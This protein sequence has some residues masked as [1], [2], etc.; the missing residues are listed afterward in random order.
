VV[1][2]AALLSNRMQG[3]V[4]YLRVPEFNRGSAK[5]IRSKLQQFERQ[6]LHKLVLDLRGCAAGEPSEAIETAQLFL[7]SGTIATLRGQTIPEQTFPADSSK[8][9]WQDP[10]TVLTSNSTAGPAEIL[11]A[12]IAGNSR[13]DTIGR[14]TLGTASEQKL[15]P[16]ED[17]SAIFLTV[18]IYYTPDNKAI[19]NA[20]VTPTVRVPS[21]NSQLAL[22]DDQD[23]APDPVPGQLPAATDPVVQKA[24]EILQGAGA[25]KTARRVPPPASNAQYAPRRDAAAGAS[26]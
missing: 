10:V 22:L 3:D 26:S 13:G 20:G 4:A 17:G 9:V 15:I 23:L 12:A 21:P 14:T 8:A 25:T 24:V 6:G 2:T 19:L 1:P 18:G 16:L 5:E 11:A 7:S